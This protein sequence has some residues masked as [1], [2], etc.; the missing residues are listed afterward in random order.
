MHHLTPRFILDQWEAGNLF[1]R[2]DAAAV[3]VDVSG[4]TTVTE[5]LMDAGVAGSEMLADI[6]VAIFEPLIAAVYDNGGYI[7]DFAGDAFMAL[8]PD[9]ESQSN[10]ARAIT[11]TWRIN[12]HLAANPIYETEHGTF[13]FAVKAGVAHGAVEWGIVGDADGWR[14]YFYR[15]QAVDLCAHAEHQARGGD[16]VLDRSVAAV[17]QNWADIRPIADRYYRIDGANPPL[18][19][20]P[21]ITAPDTDRNARAFVAA[22]LLHTSRR[23][24]F[25]DIVS[26]FVNIAGPPTTAQ[27]VAFM[28][29]FFELLARY[30]G[31][32]CRLDFGDKGCNLLLFWGAPVSHENDIQRALDFALDLQA[33]TDLTLRMGITFRMGYA[34][35]AGAPRR[36]EYT[37]YGLG[38]NLAAR[39]M[40]TA[41]WGTVLLDG[42]TAEKAGRF[43]TAYVQHVP[44]KG[45]AEPQPV[46]TLNGRRDQVR[47]HVYAGQL[48]GREQEMAQLV[49]AIRPIFDHQFAGIVTIVA[50]A[51]MGKSRLA[52]AFLDQQPIKLFLCQ[53][54]EILRQSLNPFRFWL[55]N[56]FG[57]SSTVTPDENRRQFD[58]RLDR[59]LA[60]LSDVALRE[61]LERTR[62]FLAALLDIFWPDSLYAQ[63]EPQLRFENTLSALK[64]LIKAESLVQPVV[65]L[66]EDVHWLDTDSAEFLKRLTRNV[67]DYPFA[68]LATSRTPLADGMVEETVAQTAVTLT[69]LGSNAIAQ[70]VTDRLHT[71]PS[72][73]LLE[74]LATRTDGNPFFV[75]Q[76]LLYLQENGLL[77]SLLRDDAVLTDDIIVP[78]DV[79]A[80]LVSRLDRLEPA[81]RDVVQQASVLGREFE[82]PVLQQMVGDEIELGLEVAE[83]A[84]IW[85]PLTDTRYLFQHALMRDAAY[86]MQ[87]RGR[88]RRLHGNAAHAFLRLNALTYFT[89]PPFAEIA[90]H[91]DHARE[92]PQAV[93][94]YGKAGEQAQDAYHNEDAIA[95]F[96]RGLA[97]SAEDDLNSQYKL[98]L[99]REAVLGWIGDRKAQA[100]DLDKLAPLVARMGADDLLTVSF[101]LRQA[102]FNYL[103]GNHERALAFAESAAKKAGMIS[104]EAELAQA[105][106]TW[107]RVLWKQGHY[108]AAR[109]HIEH[110]LSI[111]D[112]LPNQARSLYDLG[113]IAVYEAEFDKAR[114]LF[115]Q[116]LAIYEQLNDMRGQISCL[117]MWGVVDNNAGDYIAAA[118]RYTRSLELSNTVGWRHGASYTL[119]H[120]GNNA[121]EIGSFIQAQQ[122][123]EQALATCREIGDKEG[124]AVSLDTLGL[125]AHRLGALPQAISLF[126]Q[127]DSIQR[128]IGDPRGL[129]YTLTHLGHCLIDHAELD[130]AQVV[131]DEALALRAKLGVEP[132]L[133]D[134][135]A[136]GALLAHRQGDQDN[137]RTIVNDLLGRIEDFG[138][139]SLEF[140]VMVLLICYDVCRAAGQADTATTILL[141]ADQFLQQRAAI[142]VNMSVR[143]Q[144]LEEIPSHRRLTALLA[145]MQ[146]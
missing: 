71:P 6:M 104:A 94:Y 39:Q 48:V 79:R 142:I 74:L 77:D 5:A 86:D 93:V 66:L 63:L 114:Q 111:D 92:A 56:Y 119:G 83:S 76:M 121:F 21:V 20:A 7:T 144:F 112:S 29:V 64:A 105:E 107:G 24:E 65:V 26:V 132:R 110:A 96:S 117:G 13:E 98:L 137:G 85:Q 140:P 18:L 54:D 25:R 3:F 129:G 127:A 122:Y 58:N 10:V 53:T 143:R 115:A 38:V 141:Q 88:L 82:L 128:A 57:Q 97:L 49:A 11:A 34:G 62:S 103:I 17:A 33:A 45:F 59:L 40:M 28:S 4:F 68:V 72:A 146:P 118:A 102:H 134:T 70:L 109:N 69:T 75:E 2:F 67:A 84:A 60:I 8:F 106:H 108:A 133:A 135:M 1:G 73:A 145:E 95:Y 130:E 51:G 89:A 12:R 30:D 99:G 37:C 14:T 50:E 123:H 87:L 9:D 44:F 125:V 52:H 23:G 139:D 55:R 138:V 16:V 41:D 22:S 19:H 42:V 120:L 35:F 116:A 90:Y 81:L 32:L 80:V 136:I 78:T 61:E 43:D 91:F 31:T 27:L 113:G 131:L 126:I 47:D 15:G 46:Y 36:E 101:A 124:E 100:E